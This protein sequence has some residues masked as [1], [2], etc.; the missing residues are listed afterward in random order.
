MRAH[1]RSTAGF[2]GG[3]DG[4]EAAPSAPI[5]GTSGV[6]RRDRAREGGCVM[7]KMRRHRDV[8]G[9]T[10]LAGAVPQETAEALL[11][12]LEGEE[13][14]RWRYW[15]PFSRQ[16]FGFEY[17]ISS[18]GLNPATPIPA[19]MRDLFP[20]LRTAGWTGA[21]PEQVIVTRYPPGGKLSRHIDAPV[22][23]GV[24]AGLSL[25]AVWPIVFEPP[26]W[27]AGGGRGR[28]A[29]A[30][31]GAFGVRHVGRG[32]DEVVPPGAA[33]GGR[34]NAGV[35]HVPH[36]GEEVAQAAG[37]GA[38]PQERPRPRPSG[39]RRIRRRRSA[40]RSWTMDG[41]RGRAA[42]NAERRDAAALARIESV[43]NGPDPAD[44]IPFE[45]PARAGRTRDRQGTGR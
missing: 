42:G 17:D 41:R 28:A 37:G 1:G 40:V 15:R 4:T 38:E 10:L 34:R 6:R 30:A 16:D 43:L 31:A 9:L 21:D 8:R 25:G 24:I 18:R 45:T 44:E 20:A 36:V 19:A 13:W 22:F 12:A 35:A 3:R 11:R 32:A 7:A 2:A 26:R 27:G 33:D 39:G 14:A 5:P 29:P 23:G